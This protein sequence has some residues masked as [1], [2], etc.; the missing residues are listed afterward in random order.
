[1]T[2]WVVSTR[3]Y[4]CCFR[5]PPA[6]LLR[7]AACLLWADCRLLHNTNLN[8]QCAGQIFSAAVDLYQRF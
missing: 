7:A 8:A 4:C 3:L 1:V 5:K 2:W 6:S